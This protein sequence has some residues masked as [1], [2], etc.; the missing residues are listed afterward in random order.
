[1]SDD[2]AKD[3]PK[4]MKFSVGFGATSVAEEQPAETDSAPL[5][6]I[7]VLSGLTPTAEHARGAKKASAVVVSKKTLDEAVAAFGIEL[8]LT[9]PDPVI[10]TGEPLGVVLPIRAL[11]DFRPSSWVEHV[12]ALRA[13]VDARAIVQ[14]GGD[15]GARLSGTMPR[16]GWASALASGAAALASPPPVAETGAPTTGSSLLDSLLDAGAPAAP[17]APA[18]GGGLLGS[19]AR[20][21]SVGPGPVARVDNAVTAL[22]DA[23]LA[24]PELRRLEAAWRSVELLAKHAELPG[25]QIE[26][27]DAHVDEVDGVLDRIRLSNGAPYD[28]VLV[29]HVVH[30]QPRDLERLEAWATR[31]DQLLVPVIVP[32]EPQ[33]IGMDDVASIA[34]SQRDHARTPD[35]RA[36][37]LAASGAREETRWI[38]VALNAPLARLA[39][40]KE[41]HRVTGSTYA[42]PETRVLRASSALALGALVAQSHARFGWGCAPNATPHVML[43]DLLVSTGPDGTATPL[44]AIVDESS[45]KEAARAGVSVLCA[46]PSRD[47]AHVG[48]TAMVYRGAVGPSGSSPPASI[49]LGDQL[50]VSRMSQ[51]LT[52]LAAAL[53]RGTDVRAATEIT[54]LML[55]ELFRD[56]PSPHPEV[57]LAMDGDIVRLTVR[58]RRFLGVTIPEIELGARLSG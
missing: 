51:V 2:S 39:H 15:V 31:G 6:R 12:P 23:L 57:S 25:V 42:E 29:D 17:A 3:K 49:T 1:M 24:H 20:E 52:Q 26:L 5:F 27:F 22:L 54:Q 38:A 11:R 45:A 46:T 47:F 8:S 37:L 53:P 30:A 48:A 40:T 7:A 10:A 36:R 35:Q 33:L 43:R 50:F 55:S 14:S 18:G 19:I 44:E 41:T 56:A 28:L 13:L 32:G 16:P 21:G 4:D 9:V 34:K 58:P